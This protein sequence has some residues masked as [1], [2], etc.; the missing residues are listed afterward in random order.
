M[1]YRRKYGSRSTRRPRRA[2]FRKSAPMYRQLTVS[3]QSRIHTIVFPG[4]QKYT[5]T[6]DSTTQCASNATQ[7]SAALFPGFNG[8]AGAYQEY[9]IKS[10]R[11]RV[12]LEF[13]NVNVS[14][15]EEDSSMSPNDI[16][17]DPVVAVCDQV[18]NMPGSIPLNITP[19]SV[20][21]VSNAEMFRGTRY[22]KWRTFTPM[23][24]TT[25][26]APVGFGQYAQVTLP[27]STFIP[28]EQ[29]QVT[30]APLTVVASENISPNPNYDPQT[31]YPHYVI[32]YFGT[33]QFRQAY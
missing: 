14:Q 32:E 21:Q 33:F 27:T 13:N 8:L 19:T 18:N 1:V 23:M 6:W 22:S 31:R 25:A 28:T 7:W 24:H 30:H 10:I 17:I 12:R 16:F 4:Y 5:L 20:L 2:T 15:V 11:Y 26:I 9:R 3:P 29:P